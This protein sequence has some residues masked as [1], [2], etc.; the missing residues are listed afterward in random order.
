MTGI[1]W[2][3]CENCFS[4]ALNADGTT[5]KTSRQTLVSASERCEC[6]WLYILMYL[7]SHLLCRTTFFKLALR[8]MF[9]PALN[10]DGTTFQDV[11]SDPCQRR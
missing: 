9:S 2:V 5:S 6:R 3:P 11:S 10:A 4:P 7:T 8:A 1:R